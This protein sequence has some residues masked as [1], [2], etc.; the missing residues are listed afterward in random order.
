M[1]KIVQTENAPKPVGAYSQAV[2]AGKFFFVAG[3]LGID[4]K[5]EKMIS[6][7]II[8]QTR[9]ALE[10]VKAVLEAEA[11]RLSDVV[12]T[13]VYLSSVNLFRDFNI[14]YEKY[15][16]KEPPAR[17]TVGTALGFG[18]LVEISVIAYKE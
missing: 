7:N 15:F 9:R 8:G 6:G 1:K 5:E 2:R 18:A 17:V 10:N 12:Q 4:P 14:E 16:H 3:Q 13:N 11:Y